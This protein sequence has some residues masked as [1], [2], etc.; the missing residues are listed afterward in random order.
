MLVVIQTVYTSFW[1]SRA[2]LRGL[3]LREVNKDRLSGVPSA[4]LGP[5]NLFIFETELKES[6]FHNI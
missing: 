5:D 6:G 2:Q 1:F 3:C 4:S